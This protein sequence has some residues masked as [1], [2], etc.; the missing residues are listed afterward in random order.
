MHF[1]EINDSLNTEHRISV[2]PET[3]MTDHWFQA[4]ITLL[5]WNAWNGETNNQLSADN[6]IVCARILLLREQPWTVRMLNQAQIKIT[7][8][9]FSPTSWPVIRPLCMPQYASF[10]ALF[11]TGNL[12]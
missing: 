12:A 7:F 10:K 3:C 11:P 4:L 8:G 1:M 6:S 2:N 9:N 5:L